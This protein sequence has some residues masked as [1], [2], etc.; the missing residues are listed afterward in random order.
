M[1][2]GEHQKHLEETFIDYPSATLDQAMESLTNHFSDL[3]V[4]KTTVYNSMTQKCALSFKKAH[5]HS[6]EKDSPVSIE[7]RFDWVTRWGK[8][9]M[10]YDSNFVFID[11]PAFHINLKRTMT[12]SKK[13][14]R[15]EVVQPP[16][17][18]KTTT[19]LGAI[20]IWCC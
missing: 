12:Y 7:K 13:G 19:I 17:R 4:T 1:L 5:F 20:P 10:D 9:D 2:S 6:Y 14:T 15:A 3:K 8:T 11:E 18:A 16:T